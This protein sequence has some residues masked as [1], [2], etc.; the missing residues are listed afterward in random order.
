MGVDEWC[1]ISVVLKLS[2]IWDANVF[3]AFIFATAVM[4]SNKNDDEKWAWQQVNFVSM[5]PS[6][7]PTKEKIRRT[8]TVNL[9]SEFFRIVSIFWARLRSEWPIIRVSELRRMTSAVDLVLT[10][11]MTTLSVATGISEFIGF[12]MLKVYSKAIAQWWTLSLQ[13]RH[14]AIDSSKYKLLW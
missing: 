2:F 8:Y 7:Q 12:D 3:F 11:V 4:Q 14:L 5:I 6:P 13:V 9:F 1:L 10:T